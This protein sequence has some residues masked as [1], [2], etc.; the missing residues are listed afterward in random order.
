MSRVKSE[1]ILNLTLYLLSARRYLSRE[2]IRG[3][4]EGYGGLSDEAFERAFERD[5]DELRRLGVPI[6]TGSNSAL[7]DDEVGYRIRRHEFE[8]PPIEFTPAEAQVLGIAA[9]VW[10]QAAMAESTVT[11][12]AKLRAA[13]VEVDGERIAALAPTVS[14]RED[15][16]D[17]LWQATSR[18]RRVE[19][20]YRLAGK[21]RTVDP[22]RLLHRHG[23]WYL[24]GRDVSKD[25]PRMFK[26]SRIVGAVTELSDSYAVP[27]GIDL[28]ALTRTL[29]PAAPD[30]EALLAI[31]D[32]RAPSVSRRGTVAAGVSAPAGFT[33]FRVPY[34]E[35]EGF[36]GQICA[37]GADVIVLDPPQLV[38]AVIAQLRAI[39]GGAR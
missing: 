10:Q 27:A 21:L 6:V 26:L 17:A 18:Q 8:L 38:R 35:Q 32:D 14:A 19:F 39:A 12:M 2:Q 11:A 7:F 33:A 4:V 30:T 31:R 28:D 24:L 20:D 16:F 5:K 13:G 9:H 29:E 15:A 23:S 3:A 25:A 22:W 36:V 37:A 34:S 1:R